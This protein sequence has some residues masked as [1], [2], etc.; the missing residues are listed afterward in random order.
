MQSIGAALEPIL[1][2]L[3][4]RLALGASRWH[5]LPPAD[6]TLSLSGPPQERSGGAI[7]CHGQGAKWGGLFAHEDAR[8][9]LAASAAFKVRAHAVME[10]ARAG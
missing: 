7:L 8:A 9:R 1:L 5:A 4:A 10:H 6:G 3:Q 2:E